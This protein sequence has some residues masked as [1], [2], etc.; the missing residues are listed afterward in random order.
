MKKYLLRIMYLGTAYHGFQVQPNGITVQQVLTERLS[1]FFGES[2]D[3]KGCS[4]TDSGVHANDFCC[5]AEV[6]DFAPQV[7]IQ[8]LPEAL[9]CILPHDIAVKSAELVSDAFHVRYDVCYKEYSY[10]I[11]N[12]KQRNPFYYG[13]AWHVPYPLNVELM[14]QEAQSFVGTHDFSGF[15]ASGS[16]IV[17]TVRTIQYITVN[18]EED[19]ICIRV[20]ADGFLYNMVRIMVGTLVDISRGKIPKGKLTNLLLEGNRNES[21]MTAPACGLYLN[22]VVYHGETEEK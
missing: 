2:C 22:K 6:S 13:R 9:N 18:R 15:M 11:Y 8:A 12:R 17:D 10:L 14:H 1:D 7:P 5:T 21:G 4:R 20:A 3:V 16:K 19:L